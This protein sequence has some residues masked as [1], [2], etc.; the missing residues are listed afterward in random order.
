VTNRLLPSG[1]VYLTAILTLVVSRTPLGSPLFFT[2]VVL[3]TVAYGA[4]LPVV[5]DP[6]RT[7]PRRLL[8]TAFLFAIAFRVPLAIAPVGRDSDMVRYIWDGRVQRLGYNPYLVVPADPTV[9]HTHTDETRLMPSRNASTPYP[10]GAQLFFRL[11]VT[12]SES[13]RAMKSAL[14]LCD[15][16]TILILWR[17]LTDLDRSP[18]L[19]L[20]YAWNPLV[21]LEVAHSGHI[22]ALGAMWI[23][24]SA[25]YLSRRRTALASVTLVFAIAT[26]LLPIV[27]APLYWRRLRIRD[28]LLAAGLLSGLYW[29]FVDGWRLP[30]GAVPN[31]VAHIRFNAPVFPTIAAVTAP[32]AAA[33]FAVLAGLAVAARARYR[34]K[35]SDPAAWAWPMAVSLVCAPV[36][37]PWY[38]L[39]FTPFLWSRTTIPL[40]LWTVSVLPVY[41]VWARAREGGRWMV[42]FYIQL[43]EFGVMIAASVFLAIRSRRRI[44]LASASMD[45]LV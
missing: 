15:I 36:I 12:F 41:A 45:E 28:V 43:L 30:F 14:V 39:Y 8:L 10:P 6:R 34:R 31:V 9:A 32:Q 23:A 20:I 42:P 7:P 18:W 27:L 29:L 21:V 38:L 3:A 37:Y 16:V 11:V 19:A 4:M 33:A 17:W 2:C 35:A 44:D 26:K 25:F 24:A 40:L 1:F 22:D 13:T 5:C